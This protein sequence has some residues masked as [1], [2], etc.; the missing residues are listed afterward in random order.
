MTDLSQGDEIVEEYRE[1]TL[2][3]QVQTTAG[4]TQAAGASTQTAGAQAPT[5]FASLLQAVGVL[6]VDALL[7]PVLCV[8]LKEINDT[9]QIEEDDVRNETWQTLGNV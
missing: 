1:A 8:K 4:A 3:A 7:V 6:I 2:A 5:A 9:T